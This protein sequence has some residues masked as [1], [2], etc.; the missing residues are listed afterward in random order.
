[1][2]CTWHRWRISRAFDT[3][4][5]LPR[6]VEHHL[7]GCL[8]CREHH[9]FAVYLKNQGK[10]DFDLLV[11]RE[12]RDLANGVPAHWDSVGGERRRLQW[13]GHRDQG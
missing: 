12:I 6:S 10:K 8:R 5:P 1:M 2:L 11:G 13:P 7:R 3:D 9:N 4:S